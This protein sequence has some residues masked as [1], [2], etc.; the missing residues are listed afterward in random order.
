M[1]SCPGVLNCRDTSQR[2]LRYIEMGF[3]DIARWVKF[4]IVYIEIRHGQEIRVRIF[5]GVIQ[6]NRVDRKTDQ[7]VVMLLCQTH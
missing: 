3:T 7:L 4:D 6:T 5:I 1:A 2:D